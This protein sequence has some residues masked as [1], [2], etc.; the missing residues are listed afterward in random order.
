MKDDRGDYFR[1]AAIACWSISALLIVVPT[2]RLYSTWSDPASHA[3]DITTMMTMIAIG[4]FVLAVGGTLH[5]IG[6]RQEPKI[7][8]AD[9]QANP[10]TICRA[11]IRLFDSTPTTIPWHVV[12]LPDG[13]LVA[14]IDGRDEATTMVMESIAGNHGRIVATESVPSVRSAAGAVLGC[15][16]RVDGPADDAAGAI[17]MAY[18]IGTE[19]DRAGDHPF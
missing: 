4:V 8:A 15:L 13:S 6:D 12:D 9:P 5:K 1:M 19:P 7:K 17:R 16:V 10:A 18:A 2:F 11:V 14:I 3:L